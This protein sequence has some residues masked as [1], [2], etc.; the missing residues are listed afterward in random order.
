MHIP[1]YS[2]LSLVRWPGSPE[3]DQI[4]QILHV[5]LVG[6]A[7]ALQHRVVFVLCACAVKPRTLTLTLIARGYKTIFLCSENGA[8]LVAVSC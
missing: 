4:R 3:D 6:L 1:A 2:N 7:L 8:G 5:A